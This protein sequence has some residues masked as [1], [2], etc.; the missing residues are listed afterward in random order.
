MSPLGGNPDLTLAQSVFYAWRA[1]GDQKYYDFNAK[2]IKSISTAAKSN[3]GYAPLKDV[4]YTGSTP[5]DNQDDNLEVRVA[6]LIQ[7]RLR[8]D[9]CHSL[10][11]FAE[12]MKYL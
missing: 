6:C 2:G 1:T 7:A 3:F 8:V 11:F 9:S 4:T 12:V 10:F 5:T